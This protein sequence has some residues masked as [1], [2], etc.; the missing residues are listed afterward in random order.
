MSKI[1]F[2]GLLSITNNSIKH[3]WF[4]YTQFKDKTI[5]FQAIQF[6][7]SFVCTLIGLFQSRP[8]SDVN[9][10]VL[11]ISQSSKIIG[12]LTLR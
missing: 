12:A 8:D 3:K 7:M 9:E 2:R 6:G 11:H 10:G 4:L 1:K 5:L